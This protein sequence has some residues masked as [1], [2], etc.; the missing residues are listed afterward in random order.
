MGSKSKKPPTNL[1]LSV[2]YVYY[3]LYIYIAIY[4]FQA[5]LYSF[6]VRVRPSLVTSGWLNQ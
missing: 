2:V 4:T 5:L 3:T 1:I 6:V